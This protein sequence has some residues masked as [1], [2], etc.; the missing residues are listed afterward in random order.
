MRRD[1]EEIRY[2]IFVLLCICVV[3]VLQQW[4]LHR[5]RFMSVSTPWKME[6]FFIEQETEQYKFSTQYSI[7]G[8]QNSRENVGI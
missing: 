3:H 2:S 7:I 5:N 4:P 8:T 6:D 1:F